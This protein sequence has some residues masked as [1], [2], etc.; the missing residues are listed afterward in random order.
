MAK[1]SRAQDLLAEAEYGGNRVT[2]AI[3]RDNITGVQFHPERSGPAGLAV[4]S[5]FVGGQ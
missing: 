2:A 4:L 1:P 3:M 5:K